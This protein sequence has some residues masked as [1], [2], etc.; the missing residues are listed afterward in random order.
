MWLI[1]PYARSL[2]V[3]VLAPDGHR[4]R[5]LAAGITTRRDGTAVPRIRHPA[6]DSWYPWSRESSQSISQA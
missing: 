6:A 2:P 4:T 1:D 5:I 3:E